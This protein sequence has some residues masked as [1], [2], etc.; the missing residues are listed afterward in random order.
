MSF[1]R[2]QA[3]HKTTTTNTAPSLRAYVTEKDKTAI[4]VKESVL[5]Q[6]AGN[7]FEV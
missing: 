7:T 4:E 6:S 2:S 3:I 5:E 1:R